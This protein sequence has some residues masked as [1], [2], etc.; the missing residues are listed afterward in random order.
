MLDPSRNGLLDPAQSFAWRFIERCSC[1]IAGG[2][3][4]KGAW[5]D[6]AVDH[7]VVDLKFRG[8]G[9]AVDAE[10]N[11]VDVGFAKIDVGAEESAEKAL[12]FFEKVDDVGDC[13]G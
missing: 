12:T 9:I 1:G 10:Q 4:C 5:C 11:C 2:L 13:R 6:H 3:H 7:Q 8:A